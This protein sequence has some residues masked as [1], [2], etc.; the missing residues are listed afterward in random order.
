MGPGH[1]LGHRLREA[2]EARGW[3]FADVAAV[4][5]ISSRALAAIEREAFDEL[6][7]GIFRRAYVRAFA[8]AVGLDGD[9]LARAYVEQFEPPPIAPPPPPPRWAERAG[10]EPVPVMGAVALAG[11]L[12]AAAVLLSSRHEGSGAA[13]SEAI[14]PEPVAITAA[15]AID[16]PGPRGDAAALAGREPARVRLRLETTGQS[17]VSATSDGSRVVHRLVNAGEVLVLDAETS[18][19]LRVGDAG[20]VSYSIDGRAPRVLGAAGQPLT[21]HFTA[22]GETPGLVALPPEHE[23]A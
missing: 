1:A 7:H 4:T 14:D 12:L 8:A 17:W 9:G 6:P 2:R 21:V 13:A 15:H 19:E 20:A 10:W 22:D 5:K 11:V 3:S 16:T 23:A 18:I